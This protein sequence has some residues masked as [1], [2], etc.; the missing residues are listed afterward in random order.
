V[1]LVLVFSI[2]S[3]SSEIVPEVTKVSPVPHY[4][5]EEKGDSLS[6]S[7]FIHEAATGNLPRKMTSLGI[8]PLAK[9]TDS[10]LH[11]L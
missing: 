9:K 7:L 8:G 5:I 2:C 4:K 11:L 6:M 1:S 3:L 10:A